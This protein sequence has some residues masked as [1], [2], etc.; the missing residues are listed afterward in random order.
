MNLPPAWYY[1]A[2]AART[3]IVVLCLIVG[4]RLSGKRVG[5]GLNLLDLLLVLL[6]GN[7]VQNA[8]TQGSGDLLVGIV[9][10]IT[11]LTIDR[12]IGNLFVRRPFLESR[13]FGSPTILVSQGRLNHPAMLHEG[14]SE[15]E[16]LTAVHEQGLSDLRQVK[17]G[18]LEENGTISIIPK[19]DPSH[20]TAHSS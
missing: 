14:V 9:S 15:D 13:F 7:A 5:G 18:F 2:I 16:V 19:D 3:V 10:V 17:L 20:K 1:S 8:L 6:L 12:L 11:L 4:V